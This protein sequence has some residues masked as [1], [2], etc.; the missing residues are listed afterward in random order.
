M[1]NLGFH[2]SE[3]MKEMV[4]CREMWIFEKFYLK[5]NGFFVI[6]FTQLSRYIFLLWR[7]E[8]LKVHAVY[9]PTKTVIYKKKKRSSMPHKLCTEAWC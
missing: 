2:L 5:T 7:K 8:Y 6:N 4:N 9:C 3:H 1:L